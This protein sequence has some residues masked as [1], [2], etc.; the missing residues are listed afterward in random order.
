MAR[1]KGRRRLSPELIVA[2]A[3]ELVDRDGLDALSMR[4]LADALGVDPMSIYHHVPNKDALLRSVVEAVFEEMPQSS[5]VGD[6]TE[7]VRSWAEAYRAVAAAHPNLVLRIVSDPAAVALAATK[8]NESLFS[9]LAAAGLQPREVVGCADV[10]VDFVNGYCLAL[11]VPRDSVVDANEAFRTELGGRSSGS[12][13][14]Q[15]AIFEDRS[16]DER[17]GFGFGLDVILRGIEQ[18]RDTSV[19]G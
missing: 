13:E 17:D 16:L 5:A 19:A 3:L 18:L 15:Q 8:V 1:P 7:R 2:R 11:A 10:I 12:T 6:W 14:T 9:A 4:K